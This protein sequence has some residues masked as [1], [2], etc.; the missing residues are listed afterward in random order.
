MLESKEE[1]QGHLW[2]PVAFFT[3]EISKESRKQSHN[4]DFTEE[5][6]PDQDWEDEERLENNTKTDSTNNLKGRTNG[7]S[8]YTV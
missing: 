4:A 5:K 6:Q 1:W 7:K 8:Y 3:E 2:Q